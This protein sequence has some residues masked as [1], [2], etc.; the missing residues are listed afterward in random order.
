MLHT[1]LNCNHIASFLVP[2]ELVQQQIG[3]K[4]DM[5]LKRKIAERHRK[6]DIQFGVVYLCRECYL[7]IIKLEMATAGILK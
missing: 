6:E 5:P 7:G 4:Q 1:C 3:W 2:R